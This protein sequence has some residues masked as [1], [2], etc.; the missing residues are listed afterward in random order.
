MEEVRNGCYR[1]EVAGML[2]LYNGMIVTMDENRR[3]LKDS[4]IVIKG[5][6]IE[7]I[8]NKKDILEKYKNSGAGMKDCMGKVIY[9]GFV[10]T[11]IH[12]AQSIVRGMAEDMG[13]APSYTPSVP[14][15]DDL[16]DDESY[17]FSLLG[18]A[19]ALRFGSTII[20]DNY[21]N[22]KVNAK[23]FEALGVRA[24]VSE[25]VHDMV[26]HRLSE[27]IYE[28]DEKL[29]NELF[30]K[31]IELLE[32]YND[33]SGLITAALGPHAPDTC[34]REMLLRIA[35]AAQKYDVPITT[36]LAQ[37]RME[38]K[39]VED[40]YGISSTEL[41]REC[42]LINDRLLAAHGVFLT[43]ENM[44]ILKKH[45]ANVVHIPEG[46]AK[47]GAIAAIKKMKDK[48]INVAIGTDNGAGNMIENMR[49][50]LVAGRIYNSKVTDPLPQELLEMATINGAKALHMDKQIGSLEEGKLADMILVDY[51]RLHMTPCMNVI[52]NL[53]HLGLGN[54]IETVIVDGKIVVENGHVLNIDEKE[55]MRDARRIAQL[56]WSNASPDFDREKMY[57][58]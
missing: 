22:A 58:F 1:V 5:N 25:R 21:A 44:D 35:A 20:S 4:A 55:V 17:V 24:V 29:G 3:I 53:V 15:G 19:T 34:S 9:P 30:D 10:N 51:D 46:N 40:T 48:G 39:R 12:T 54:D 42:G 28:K 27:G 16:T 38:L 41:M 23:A 13:R 7:E 2:I 49:M 18:A 33:K 26:F 52:G 6:R 11:H 57:I 43:D 47:A 56:K 32:K 31:N 45:N 8:G 50:A 37:S 36:H 14:Q